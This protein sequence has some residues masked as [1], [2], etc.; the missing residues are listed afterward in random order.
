MSRFQI[1]AACSVLLAVS[2][3]SQPSFEAAYIRPA[4]PLPQGQGGFKVRGGPGSSDPGLAMLT[5]IDLSSLIAM[6]Y[7]LQRHQISGPDWLTATRFDIAARVPEHATVDEY[8]RMLQGLLTERFALLEHRT[9]KQLQVYALEV[10]KDGPKMK[11]YLADASDGVKPPPPYSSPPIGYQGAVTVKLTKASMQ[12]VASILSGLLGEPV[13]DVTGLAGMY[14][15]RVRA[16]V[17][18]QDAD[19]APDLF[20]ALQE[21]LGLRL[22]RKKLSVEVLVVD[23]IEKNPTDN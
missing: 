22:V 18:P 23:R 10:A 5:N 2:V 15:V 21:Q 13:V 17:R 9:P 19:S 4:A 6:A 1:L 16:A 12:R 8:R 7:G 20:V 3:F 11:E 14:D